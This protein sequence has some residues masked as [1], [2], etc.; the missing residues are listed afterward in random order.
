MHTKVGQVIELWWED[1]TGAVFVRG[2]MEP[3]AARAILVEFYASDD[4]LYPM[5][6]SSIGMPRARW[7]RWSREIGPDG[8]CG[9]LR[10]Y[11][12]AG[13]GRF[14]VMEAEVVE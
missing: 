14:A 7:G 9:V 2:H 5:C 13:R 12:E 4:S 3:E 6:E 8:P 1:G 10:T 11:D